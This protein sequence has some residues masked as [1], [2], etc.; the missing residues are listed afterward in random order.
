MKSF[1]D[2]LIDRMKTGWGRF[3][4]ASGK[5]RTFFTVHITSKKSKKVFTSGIS[6]WC[7]GD[8]DVETKRPVEPL[9]GGGEGPGLQ[10]RV[11]DQQPLLYLLHYLSQVKS[12]G[13]LIESPLKSSQIW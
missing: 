13:E 2:D 3:V 12:S 9:P 7:E 5:W 8:L 10:G 1:R 11:G 6:V 4:L